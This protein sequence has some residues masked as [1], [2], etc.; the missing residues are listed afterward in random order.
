M[1][2]YSNIPEKNAK[3]G[4][5]LKKILKKIT[6]GKIMKFIAVMLIVTVYVLLLG[7]MALAKDR[8]MMSKYIVFTDSAVEQYESSPDNFTVMSQQLSESI[9]D[10]GY[11]RI[12]SY[13]FL[14]ELGELQLTVRYN[15]S[16]LETLKAYYGD[17]SIA[18]EVFVFTLSDSSGKVYDRYKFAASS[19]IIYNF[20][21]IVFE[22]VD[23]ENAGTLYLNV[24][25]VCD[26][27]KSAPMSLSFKLYDEKNT[28]YESKLKISNK[29]SYA[30]KFKDSPVF[31]YEDD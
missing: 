17:I 27:S 10:G 13:A 7:R 24:Y 11:Y 2:N 6:F 18:D 3:S 31:V 29:H 23:F 30:E 12:S 19:N 26:A 22:G 16:T 9:D 20:R 4:S 14:P 15:N 28:T 8:G 1:D 5:K 25:Y 21:R